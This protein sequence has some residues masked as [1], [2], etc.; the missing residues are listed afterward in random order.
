MKME[1]LYITL[2]KLNQQSGLFSEDFSFVG[3]N[4]LDMFT[5]SN[6]MLIDKNFKMDIVIMF[7]A[8]ESQWCI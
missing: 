7:L 8:S 4:L 1:Y 5:L 2:P 6:E 3:N